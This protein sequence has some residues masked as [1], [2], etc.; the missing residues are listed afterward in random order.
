MRRYIAAVMFFLLLAF[1]APAS[2]TQPPIPA[3]TEGEKIKAREI[4]LN[5]PTVQEI[6]KGKSYRIGGIGVSHTGSVKT[7]AIVEII[8][9]KNYWIE[10]QNAWAQMLLVSVDLEKGRV[11]SIT[12][13]AGEGPKAPA[14]VGRFMPHAVLMALAGLAVLGL[15]VL[16]LRKGVEVL[17]W[18]IAY[19]LLWY[20]YFLREYLILLGYLA[21]GLSFFWSAYV[22]KALLGIPVYLVGVITSFATLLVARYRLKLGGWKLIKLYAIPHPLIISLLQAY[23]SAFYSATDTPWW[24]WLFYGAIAYLWFIAIACAVSSALRRVLP[25]EGGS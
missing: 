18:A 6:L 15:L 4:A 20:S 23:R 17:T 3:L 11:T 14:G 16:K 22:S 21:A 12:A 19:F 1:S 5:D 7:G 2:G 8:L 13:I 25:T 10:S 9:D 24:G